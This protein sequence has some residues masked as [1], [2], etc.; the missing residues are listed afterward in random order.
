MLCFFKFIR[1]KNPN[2]N[3]TCKNLLEYVEYNLIK[4]NNE[5]KIIIGKLKNEIIIKYRNY[6]IKLN[7]KDLS[8]L[9][10]SKLNSNNEAYEFII[11]IFKQNK[12]DIIHNKTIKLLLKININNIEKEIEIILIYNKNKDIKINKLN[13]ITFEYKNIITNPKN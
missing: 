12:V 8:N 7:Y 1:P 2:E 10:K 3:K 11:N 4:N 9:I 6:E 13:N 5:Y